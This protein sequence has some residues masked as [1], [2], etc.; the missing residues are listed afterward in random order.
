MFLKKYRTTIGFALL[1]I[2]IVSAHYFVEKTTTP[3]AE[4]K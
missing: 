1:T 3:K 2:F 4:K